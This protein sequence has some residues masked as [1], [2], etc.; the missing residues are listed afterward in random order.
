MSLRLAYL[1]ALRVFGWLAL[2]TSMVGVL[3]WY[4]LASQTMTTLLSRVI[5][6]GYSYLTVAYNYTFYPI[7]VYQQLGPLVVCLACVGIVFAL[8]KPSRANR[9]LLTGWFR[10]TYAFL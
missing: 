1:A 4:V 2:L 3:P 9:I 8:L 6:H 5:A 7:K 10:V